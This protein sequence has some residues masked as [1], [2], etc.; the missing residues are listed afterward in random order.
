ML[1]DANARP[2]PGLEEDSNKLIWGRVSESGERVDKWVTL[3]G[4]TWVALFS[5]G[6]NLVEGSVTNQARENS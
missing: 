3:S 5:S 4:W 2:P 1:E 6:E